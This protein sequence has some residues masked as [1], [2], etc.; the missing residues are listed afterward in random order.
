[1]QARPDTFPWC[2]ILPEL[3]RKHK[4]EAAFDV[5]KTFERFTYQED[6]SM[7]C[8]NEQGIH[9]AR[10]LARLVAPQLSAAYGATGAA[11]LVR[12]SARNETVGN[13]VWR[14]YMYL[15]GCC[16]T[17]PEIIT[18]QLP[19][20]SSLWRRRVDDEL[21]GWSEWKNECLIQT[22]FEGIVTSPG[23]DSVIWGPHT[24]C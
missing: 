8:W 20:P 9:H 12:S 13:D 17:D 19:Q 6:C 24:Y 15:A 23:D 14:L 10:A 7:M 22:G 11:D 18:Q 5:L 21:A 4:R 1:M 2:L 3:E 16:L